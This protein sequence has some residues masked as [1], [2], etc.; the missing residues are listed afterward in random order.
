MTSWNTTPFSTFAMTPDAGGD[1]AGSQPGVGDELP[2]I[3]VPRPTAPGPLGFVDVRTQASA[4]AGPADDAES[5]PADMDTVDERIEVSRT[6]AAA[7]QETFPEAEAEPAP[8]RAPEPEPVIFEERESAPAPAAP[9]AAAPQAPAAAGPSSSREPRT[10][11]LRMPSIEIR[12]NG[13][14]RSRRVVGLKIGAS[15][16]A[17]AVIE[18]NEGRHELIQ[19][20][21]EPLGAGIVVEGEVRDPDALTRA[22]RGFFAA[23]QLPTRDVRIGLASNRI[24]VRTFDIVGVDDESRFDNAV[25]FKAHEV[26][27][28][29]VH[30]SV[31]D[32]RV[33]GER[34]SG[35]GEQMRHIFLV[36]APRDQVQPYVDVAREAGLRLR[37][38]DL[39]A[40][41]L[42]RAFVDTRP[43]GMP[44]SDDRATVVV[45]IGHEA[46]TLLVSGGGT[47]EFTRV[48]DWGGS[49]L[50]DGI[51]S[52]LGVRPDEAAKILHHLSLSGPGKDLPGFDGE[53]RT[54]A[55]E[56]VRLRLTPFARE[57]VSSLQFYQ[58]QPDSLGI[59]EIVITGGT[60]QLEGLAAA[61][62][63][64]IG[65][66]VRV[67]DPL[68]RVVVRRP[69]DAATEA[70][71]GSL[72]I[73]IGLA[74]DDSPT[75]AVDLIPSEARVAQRTTPS[76][77]SVILPAAVAVPVAALT[78]LF[79]QANGK[80][81]DRQ[82]QLSEAKA[83]FAA[84][85]VPKRP[86]LDPALKPQ[87]AARATAVAEVLGSRLAWDAVLRDVSRVL[88]GNVW[89][90]DLTAKVA[91]P[92]GDA[93]AASPTTTA[94][95]AATAV[96]PAAPEEPTGVT[97]TGFTYTQSDVA[98]LLARLGTVPS[99]TNVQLESTNRLEEKGKKTVIE[100]TI[101]ADLHE[102]G[103]AK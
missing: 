12:R 89:L 69:F 97:I 46:S 70:A 48:F 16:L 19:L 100:F 10:I 55:L 28:V 86:K 56:A 73:P 43:T 95:A 25:R 99:L 4:G 75:R 78:I 72:A 37:G 23:N 29:S 88:P 21:R 45:A 74:I 52:E 94:A 11:R 67:G 60:S 79:M 101:L 34:Y 18:E 38:I 24:G 50:E 71:M 85:P 90:N 66:S 76:L 65:V 92:L 51:A 2:V 58:S 49:S 81:N 53:R 6:E 103:G 31:L 96:G 93:S 27:P 9:F 42:L 40:L 3:P 14:G 22:I 35:S 57:L 41:A 32:Y 20:V 87:Q 47:C 59:G 39:E 30:E 83:E 64:M 17:A 82:Q 80:V 54:R 36:V 98:E 62:N 26:L 1:E 61:L 15:Q 7:P 8:E 5:T 68:S 63:Q 33:L 77:A 44:V 102:S 91:T 13:G 84:L